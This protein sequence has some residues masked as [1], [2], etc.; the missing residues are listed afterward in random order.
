[1]FHNKEQ[2]E[3][4]AN[5]INKEFFPNRLHTAKKLDPYDLLERMD[6]TP[7]WKYIS[8]NTDILGMTFFEDGSWPVWDTGNFTN[9]ATPHFESFKKGTIIINQAILDIKNNRNQENYIVAHE[10][11]HWI[12]DQD[13]FSSNSDTI[14]QICKK[15]S[16]GSTY[17]NNSMS[18]LEII[19]RQTNYLCTAILLPK[20]A[21]KKEFFHPNADG[22]E[23]S[24]HSG[25]GL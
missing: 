14:V 22:W 1:M 7:V 6:C 4:M 18:E 20:D 23:P 24:G 9:G 21:L 12:K 25:R 13:Y 15:N 10:V 16:F 2:L 3:K 19:E 8:P 17:W 11:A 5:G